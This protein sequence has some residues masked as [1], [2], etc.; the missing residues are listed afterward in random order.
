MTNSDDVKNLHKNTGLEL[1]LYLILLTCHLILLCTHLAFTRKYCHHRKRDEVF[2]QCF[3]RYLFF[4]LMKQMVFSSQKV[5]DWALA[6]LKTIKGPWSRDIE[7]S[8]TMCPN[9]NIGKF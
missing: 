4:Q 3:H 7:T 9:V 6:V 1:F 2:L 8:L 5:T